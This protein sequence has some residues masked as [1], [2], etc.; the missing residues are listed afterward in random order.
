MTK[1][2]SLVGDPGGNG[3]AG[4][5]G[6]AVGKGV[7]LGVKVEVAVPIGKVEDGVTEGAAVPVDVGVKARGVRVGVGV[8]SCF[9]K[10]HPAARVVVPTKPN[11]RQKGAPADPQRRRKTFS[12]VGVP[13]PVIAH[14]S[15]QLRGKMTIGTPCGCHW[16]N[17]LASSGVSRMQPR[18]AG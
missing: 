16:V 7:G 2:P 11:A 5:V 18:E 9:P 8:G 17:Q 13:P 10:P 1:S 3:V 12:R 4:G 15:L 14:Y 6:V